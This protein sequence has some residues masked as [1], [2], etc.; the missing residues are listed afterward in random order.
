MKREQVTAGSGDGA[1]LREEHSLGLLALSLY[2]LGDTGCRVAIIRQDANELCSLPHSPP[3]DYRRRVTGL[4]R[5]T[6]LIRATPLSRQ[7]RPDLPQLRS[8]RCAFIKGQM[9]ANISGGALKTLLAYVERQPTG[10]TCRNRMAPII[11]LDKLNF[12]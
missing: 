12:P 6:P 2:L 1:P 9:S 5:E 4:C 3:L 11:Q 7:L 10:G 8:P